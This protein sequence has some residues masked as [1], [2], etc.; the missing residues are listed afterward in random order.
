MRF[1][2]SV[3]VGTAFLFLASY[4]YF[5]RMHLDTKGTTISQS[6]QLARVQKTMVRIADAEGEQLTAYSECDSMDDLISNGKLDS[7]DKERAGYSFAIE[8]DGGG[9]NF[10][11]TGRHAPAKPGSSLRWPELI[12]DQSKA[13]HA[14]Y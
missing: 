12:I 14:V 1:L 11:V 2:I 7:N 10:T 6:I 5:T 8:C 9:A 3:V 4:F 13:V